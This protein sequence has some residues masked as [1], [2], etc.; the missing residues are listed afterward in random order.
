[1][2]R[3]T[4]SLPNCSTRRG[5]FALLV[6]VMVTALVAVAP[7]DESSED[8]SVI[9]RIESLFAVHYVQPDDEAIPDETE[10]DP[11]AELESLLQ[12]PVLVPGDSAAT[13]TS[14]VDEQLV[15]IG[16]GIPGLSRYTP[17]AV[18]RIDHDMIWL[19]G[20]RSLNEAL[21]IFVPNLELITM[22]RQ[23]TKL[24]IR[25][26]ISNN[27]D[28][29]L[30]KVNGKIMNDRTRAGAFSELDLPML[31]DIHHVDVLISRFRSS[32]NLRDNVSVDVRESAVDAVVTKCQ[33]SVI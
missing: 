29:V 33:P 14:I 13:L 18:T 20:A 10:L 27:N 16:G 21:D 6:G 2:A 17:A 8:R 25:G 22:S 19:S 12:A 26:I 15:S 24:G 31:G 23:G 32:E 9:N 7:A 28:K 1:M 11:L 30:L 5:A 4:P 3:R